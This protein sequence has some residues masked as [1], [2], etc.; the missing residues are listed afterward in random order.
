MKKQENDQ[1]KKEK[2]HYIKPLLTR[3]QKL[4]NII[5]GGRGSGPV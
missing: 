4:T 1:T 5:A 3:H 2:K